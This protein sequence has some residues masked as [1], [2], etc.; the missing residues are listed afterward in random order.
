[1]SIPYNEEMLYSKMDELIMT[2][3]KSQWTHYAT[4]RILQ[5]QCVLCTVIHGGLK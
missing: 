1:M 2:P 3:T 4:C 5:S